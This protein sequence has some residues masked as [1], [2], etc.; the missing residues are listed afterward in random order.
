MGDAMKNDDAYAN[1]AYIPGAEGY[2]QRWEDQSHAFRAD[3]VSIGR[4]Q[5]NIPYGDHPRQFN[6]LFL[7]AGRPKGLLVFIHG[8]YWRMLDGARFSHLAAGGQGRDWAVAMPTYVLTPEATIPEI[9]AMIARAIAAAAARAAGPIVVTGHSA[10]GHLSARMAMDAV[11]PSDVAAR[12]QKIVPI[13]ALSDLRPLIKTSMNDDF[14]LTEDAAVAESPALHPKALDVPVHTWVG[15]AERPAFLDQ[16]RWLA[17]AWGAEMTVVP[18]L[19][20]FNV[21]E[22]LADPESDLMKTLLYV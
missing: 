3:E 20:H 2:L 7:P 17:E 10:G 6:D 12:V 14:K 9:T 19:H 16:S 4:A 11:L 22:A 15:G 8:G 13:S 1:A 21:I 18:D 5:L